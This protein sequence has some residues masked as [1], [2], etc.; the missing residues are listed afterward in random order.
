[1][2]LHC[3]VKKDPTPQKGTDLH[4]YREQNAILSYLHKS[5]LNSKKTTTKDKI[6]ACQRL[7]TAAGV[8]CAGVTCKHKLDVT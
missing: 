8:T 5:N 4:R 3:M 6:R 2:S 1:M 7:V